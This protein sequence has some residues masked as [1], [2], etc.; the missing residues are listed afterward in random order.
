MGHSSLGAAGHTVF[1][2]LRIRVVVA[3][4]ANIRCQQSL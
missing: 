4:L 3:R 2:Y 1:G